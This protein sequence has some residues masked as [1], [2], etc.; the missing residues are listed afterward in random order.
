[1][2][3]EEFSRLVNMNGTTYLPPID[4]LE[5]P[6]GLPSTPECNNQFIPLTQFAP[7]MASLPQMPSDFDMEVLAQMPPPTPAN[8]MLPGKTPLD[9]GDRFVF[10][11]YS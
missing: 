1:M 6:D 7:E 2:T 3:D 10:S 8:G 9:V 4:L 11:Q 5:Y